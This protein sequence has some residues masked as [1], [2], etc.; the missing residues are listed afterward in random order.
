[1]V[2]RSPQYVACHEA[3]HAIIALSEGYKVS[4]IELWRDSAGKWQG[5]TTYSPQ[6][7]KCKECG[8]KAESRH[9]PQ[10]LRILSNECPSCLAEKRRFGRRLLAG[11]SATRLLHPAEHNEEDSDDDRA[12]LGALYPC[13]S[14]ARESAFAEGR[15]QADSAV[16]RIVCKIT[17]LRE[18]IL[19]RLGSSDRVVVDSTDIEAVFNR[20]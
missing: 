18:F 16:S 2:G 19:D 4:S 7:F 10:E 8:L 9:N 12:Q 13:R 5:I 11:A 14:S 6:T 20:R 3:G 15:V 17:E 1:M